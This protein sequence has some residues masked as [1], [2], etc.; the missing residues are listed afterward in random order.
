MI[1]D[2]SRRNPL[3][4]REMDS[5]FVT[6]A[7]LPPFEEFCA[8]LA[9]IFN[10]AHLTNR[11]PLHDRLE[12][13]IREYLRVEHVHLVANGTL[14]LQLALA[15]L[16]IAEGEV[17]T[18][19]F[20]YAAT[21][22]AIMWERCVPVFV[23]IEP[24]NFT[25]DPALI[26][27]AITDKTRAILPVHVFG[28]AC[29]VEA[30]ENLAARHGLKVIYDAA[31][32]FGGLW[33]G[34]SLLSFGDVSTCSFHATKLFHTAEGGCCVGR[35]AE[36][37][38]AIYLIRSF[39]HIG[40]DHFR[41]GMNAKMSELQAAMGLSIFPYLPEIIA[42]RKAASEAYDRRLAGKLARP[43]QQ[44]ALEYNFAYY[45]VLFKSEAELLRIIG[46]LSKAD[47]H[48]RRYFYPALNRLPYVPR[49]AV[50]PIAEDVSSRIACLPLY[51]G[52]AENDVERI[53]M[54]IQ[55]NL[56]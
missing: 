23:D 44:A 42:S 5:I 40:D 46:A 38:R 19:P 20:S 15:G 11:G 12:A 51:S 18:T 47:I 52:L 10:T 30:I 4:A 31:H 56:Y 1:C 28:Y 26:E 9:E 36:V 49:R 43:A 6:R 54:I 35:E 24:G 53:C 8:S 55:E 21:V 16:G 50:C 33:Q 3:P 7:Y 45:P 29:D 2:C 37:S 41:L 13:K 32:A 27:A 48:P 17:I 34:R 25:L 14:A 39:G 22:S